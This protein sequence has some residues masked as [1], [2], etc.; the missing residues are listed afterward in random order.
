MLAVCCLAGLALGG[1]AAASEGCGAATHAVL[2]TADA[3]VLN[4]IY[5]NENAGGEVT[6]DLA[7]ITG[8][9]ALVSAVTQ[10][11]AAETFTAVEKLVYH[12]GWH[13]VRLRVLDASGHL[14]ADVG[15]PYVIAPVS[16]V[17][18]SPS[19][20]VI[21]SFLMSVQDDVGVTKLETRFVG[22]PIGIYYRGHRVA[23]LG[24]VA[25]PRTRPTAPLLTVGG[26]RYLAMTETYN[27]FPS[28]T[29]RAVILVPPPAQALTSES[30][31]SVRAGEFGR[32]ASLL[33]G[34]LGPVVQHYYGF[35]YWVHV[36]TA[37]DVFVLDP[38]G[39]VIAASNGS[40]PPPL[41]LTGTV[42]YQGQNWLVFSFAPQP[43]TRVY[44]LVAPG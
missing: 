29:L 30:C 21:G 23:E 2:A 16:G 36:Y 31:A 22:D 27:A 38:D 19:G 7:E 4:N 13:I 33:T 25:L 11:D 34:L 12:P 42:A 43:P 37:A 24:S 17:L 40:T 6:D 28:G 14:L 35:A 32:V 20:A 18:R 39:S 1:R 5:A 8:S 10:D 15:G 9:Q 41:P 44:L 26:V 3:Q